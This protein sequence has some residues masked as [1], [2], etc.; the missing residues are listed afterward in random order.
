MTMNLNY[1]PT[2]IVDF[3]LGF[4]SGALVFFPPVLVELLK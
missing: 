2:Q 1:F 3:L 4:I